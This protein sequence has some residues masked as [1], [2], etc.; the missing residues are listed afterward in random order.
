MKELAHG[1]MATAKGKMDFNAEFTEITEGSMNNAEIDLISV[2][3][4][5]SV[6]NSFSDCCEARP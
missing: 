4:A 3:S 5:V 6:L 1:R 2:N